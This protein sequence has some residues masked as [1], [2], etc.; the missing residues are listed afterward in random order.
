VLRARL[1]AVLERHG[2]ARHLTF[3]D[4]DI[5]LDA[6]TVRVKGVTVDL[7]R[8]EFDLLGLLASHPGRAFSRQQILDQVWGTDFI[9]VD[10]VVD[11]RISHLRRKIFDDTRELPLIT[12]VFGVG[13]RFR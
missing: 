6:R 10:R 11:V 12:T 4:V 8:G 1:H 9:G 2:T 3:G 5:N 13:Y 7:T